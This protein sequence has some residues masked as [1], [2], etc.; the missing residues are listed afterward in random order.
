MRKAREARAKAEAEF[1]ERERAWAEAKAKGEAEIARLTDKSREK[2]EFEAR[3]RKN[4]NA[5]NRAAV[6]ASA[7]IRFSAKIH[8]QRVGEGDG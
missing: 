5:V 3:V 2:A 6:E 1:I 4:S 7:K 8:I